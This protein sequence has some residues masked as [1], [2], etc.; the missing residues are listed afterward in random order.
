M[1]TFVIRLAAIAVMACS[2]PLL[3]AA[4]DASK[5]LSPKHGGELFE[6]E[7]HAVEMVLAGADLSFYVS[8]HGE[9]VDVTGAAFKAVV[10]TPAGTK[11][12]DLKAEGSTLSAKLDAAP[13]AGSKIAV[14]GKDKGGDL[15]QARFVVK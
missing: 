14:T 15:I 3:A 7:H 2:V 12:I 1:R 13:P 8:E 6:F 4:H 10:Q 5:P 9:E 11:A